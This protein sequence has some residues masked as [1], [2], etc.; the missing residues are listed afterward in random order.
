[1][2]LYYIRS[3][4]TADIF[5]LPL[6]LFSGVGFFGLMLQ[7]LVRGLWLPGLFVWVGTYDVCLFLRA[8]EHYIYIWAFCC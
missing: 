3:Q 7:L 4:P 6:E 2:V 8:C 1:M 5:L